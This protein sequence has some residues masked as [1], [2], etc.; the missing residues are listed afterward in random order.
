[1]SHNP[2][3]TKIRLEAG[4][5]DE[6]L[7]AA[8]SSNTDL[9]AVLNGY[10]GRDA[11]NRVQPYL[12]SSS[13]VFASDNIYDLWQ[14]RNVFSDTSLPPSSVPSA[15]LSPSP[16]QGQ[17]TTPV[18][19]QVP[20]LAQIQEASASA[21]DAGPSSRM[22]AEPEPEAPNDS[23]EFLMQ[24]VL[25]VDS[26]GSCFNALSY[27]VNGNCVADDGR[28]D[29]SQLQD[30]WDEREMARMPAMWQWSCRG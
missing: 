22:E 29:G 30:G 16:S 17:E 4:H 27:A 26:N 25:D 9:E 15:T 20:D 7:P 11:Q 13:A 10:E 14:L 28:I 24:D 5:E 2:E 6:A 19:Y 3:S 18:Q 23:F 12:S 8:S 1:M 21:A